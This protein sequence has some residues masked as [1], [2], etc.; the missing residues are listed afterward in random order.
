MRRA[1]GSE[2]SVSRKDA[3]APRG[4]R[5][6]SDDSAVAPIE[7][8]FAPKKVTAG[9]QHLFLAHFPQQSLHAEE[10]VMLERL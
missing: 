2:G 7:R 9:R 5:P 3:E 1:L 6:A 10:I 8:R 4:S